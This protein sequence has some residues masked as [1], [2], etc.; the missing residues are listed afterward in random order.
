MNIKDVTLKMFINILVVD[1]ICLIVM[2]NIEVAK[3]IFLNKICIQILQ[4]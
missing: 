1:K 4:T 3:L 2:Y